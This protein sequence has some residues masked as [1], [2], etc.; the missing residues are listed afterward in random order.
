MV[1]LSYWTNRSY[2]FDNFGRA[3]H[4]SLS[5]RNGWMDGSRCHLVRKQA[6]ARQHCVRWAPISATKR[7][8]AP[9]PFGPCLCGQTAKRLELDGSR[10]HSLR[11]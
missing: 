7:G 1:T 11:M 4:V 6:S 5:W 8:T 9:A 2:Q 10:C 3:A